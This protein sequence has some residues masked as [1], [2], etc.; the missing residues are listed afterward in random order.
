MSSPA[1]PPPRRFAFPPGAGLLSPLSL[2]ALVTWLAVVNGP[3]LDF[4]SSPANRSPLASVGIGAQILMLLLFVLR[5]IF[6]SKPTQRF[7]KRAMVVGQALAVL[8]AS[9]IF[10]DGSQPVLLIIV[11]SQAALLFERRG[12]VA[13]LILMNLGLATTLLAR[14]PDARLGSL[15]SALAAYG[16][17]QAFAVLLASYAR[18]VELARDAAQQ[19]NAELLATRELLA[20]GTRADERLNLSREL[21]DVA[22]HKLTALKLQLALLERRAAPGT[23]DAHRQLHQLADELLSDVRAVVST[24][25]HHDG[26]DLQVAL[27]AL[28]QAFPQPQIKLALAPDARAPS[29]AQAETLLRVAQEAL[30]NAARHSGAHRVLLS[31]SRESDR[32]LLTVSDDGVGLCGATPG[33]GLTGMRERL[34]VWG[35]DLKLH[36]APGGGLQLCASLPLA[37]AAVSP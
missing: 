37:P 7:A 1:Q 14:T 33:N 6:D 35:G 32:L 16:G 19:L 15:L 31:L 2:A 17:F 8:L 22:G 4:V 25:R 28:A 27:T 9:R 11:A 30:A 3:W 23:A 10:A 20:A 21:H 5:A 18:K 12:L 29:I 34:A 13:F 36:D 24:L 26:I